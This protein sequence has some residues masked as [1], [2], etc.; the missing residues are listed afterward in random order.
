MDQIT[1]NRGEIGLQ[2]CYN[3]DK[4]ND[5]EVCKNIVV[6]DFDDVFYIIDIFERWRAAALRKLEGLNEASLTTE[7]LNKIIQLGENSK[8]QV[9]NFILQVLLQ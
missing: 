2:I 5:S 4:A 9:I 1:Q 3:K 6:L 8:T 7:E